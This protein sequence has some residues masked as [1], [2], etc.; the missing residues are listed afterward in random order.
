MNLYGLSSRS[1]RLIC[2]FSACLLAVGCGTRSSPSP[3]VAQGVAVLDAGLEM[4]VERTTMRNTLGETNFYGPW[5]VVVVH[6][7]NHS[8]RPVYFGPMLQELIIEGDSFEPNAG[9]AEDFD[10]DTTSAASLTP[11][12]DANV[13]LAF[14]VGKKARAFA[15]GAGELVLRGDAYSKG[16]VVKLN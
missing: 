6:V 14:S 4:T 11:G 13:A 1:L 5:A 12:R 10:G 8:D 3:V 7:S 16:T 2:L 15:N 9:A